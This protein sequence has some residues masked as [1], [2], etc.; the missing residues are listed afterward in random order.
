VRDARGAG[1]DRAQKLRLFDHIVGGREQQR[2]HVDA[3]RPCGL[4]VENELKSGGG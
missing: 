1:P 3:E 2:R 4:Q